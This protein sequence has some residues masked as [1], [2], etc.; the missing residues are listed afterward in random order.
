M[1]KSILY[2][3]LMIFCLSGLYAANRKP[4]NYYFSHI[5][6]EDGLSESQ[7]K[8][9]LQDSYG[10]MWFGTKNGLNR[11]DGTS[12]Q[13]FNC[14]DYITGTSNHNISALFEDENKKLWVGTDRGVYI[15]D[16]VYDKFSFINL[17]AENGERMFNWVARITSDHDGNIWVLIPDQGAFRYKDE[18][19]YYYAITN[20]DNIKRESTEAIC[21][22]ENGEVWIGTAGV[23]IFRYNPETDSFTQYHTDKNGNSLMG[24]HIFAMCEYGDWIAL[25]IHD[26]ELKKYNPVTNV[27]Q[28]VKAPGVHHTILRDVVC[29]DKERLWVCTHAG[30][31]IVDEAHN[32]VTHL[33]EDPMHSYNLS[34]NIIFCIHKGALGIFPE[35]TSKLPPTP[36]KTQ[37]FPNS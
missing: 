6:S 12:I 27:L 4:F 13:T 24:E 1:R 2:L 31:F 17:E 11:Y 19:L 26:G 9:I 34:D 15:Y 10:F 5:S 28:T 16:P 14:D 29:L 20:K 3:L 33:E 25:A 7:V 30:L 35:I 22:K 36:I 32:K 37:L 21:V 23:G 8:V 18:K